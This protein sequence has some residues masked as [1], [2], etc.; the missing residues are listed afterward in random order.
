MAQIDVSELLLDPDFIDAVTLIHRAASVNQ[1]GENVLVE[2]SEVTVGS[3]Q[4]ISGK[5]FQRLP[6]AL[7]TAD[8]RTFYIKATIVSDGTNT[9]PDIIVFQNER[10]QVQSVDNWLNYGQG[11]NS[12]ICVREKIAS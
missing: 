1:Y 4:P 10:Y 5:Q 2:T 7:R 9:Y 11:Y 3:V 8:V 6:D 12:G